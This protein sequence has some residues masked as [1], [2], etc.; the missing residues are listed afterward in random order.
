MTIY[1]ILFDLLLV[2]LNLHV[3]DN[4]ID[5]WALVEHSLGDLKLL[6]IHLCYQ[7]LQ[8]IVFVLQLIDNTSL[9]FNESYSFLCIGLAV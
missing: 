2:D 9:L 4:V 3:I 1:L 5:V 8:G 6:G 7:V